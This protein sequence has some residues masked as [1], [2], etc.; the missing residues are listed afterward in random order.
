M[1]SKALEDLERALRY[2]PNNMQLRDELDDIE[3]LFETEGDGDFQVRLRA[4][5]IRCHLCTFTY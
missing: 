5:G 4:V 1:N 3:E 2:E